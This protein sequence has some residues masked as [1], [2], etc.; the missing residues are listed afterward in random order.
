MEKKQYTEPLV[1]SEAWS[2][3]DLMKVSGGVSNGGKPANPA[4][5]RRTPTF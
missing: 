2:M 1:Q 5:A 3:Q 4:P